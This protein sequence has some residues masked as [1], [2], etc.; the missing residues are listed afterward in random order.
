MISDAGEIKF[1]KITP[2]H[3]F[4]KTETIPDATHILMK[5]PNI[6]VNGNISFSKFYNPNFPLSKERSLD[7][8]KL[9][10]RVD[11]VDNYRE[12]NNNVSETKYITYL[13]SIQFE[14][15]TNADSQRQLKLKIPGNMD[16]N[17]NE[18]IKLLSSPASIVALVMIIFITT[19]FVWRFRPKMGMLEGL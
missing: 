1:N 6:K 19:M 3:P 13:K 16:S 18:T 10:T 4:S 14:E 5:S 17:A 7:A 15:S 11:H 12:T 2:Q 8:E 9:V